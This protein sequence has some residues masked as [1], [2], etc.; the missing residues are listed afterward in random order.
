M[1]HKNKSPEILIMALCWII[2]GVIFLITILTG[3]M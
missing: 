2:L 3:W 1:N